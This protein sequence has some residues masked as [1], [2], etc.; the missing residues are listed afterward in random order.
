MSAPISVPILASIGY[1][2]YYELFVAGPESRDLEPCPRTFLLQVL[3]CHHCRRCRRLLQLPRSHRR[4]SLALT[5]TI[6]P[7][8]VPI[9]VESDSSRDL[10][11]ANSLAR[12]YAL[13]YQK[14]S[15]PAQDASA[16]RLAS[17]QLVLNP[18]HGRSYPKDRRPLD[19]P[20]ACVLKI[21]VVEEPGTAA[22]QEHEVDYECALFFS[23]SYHGPH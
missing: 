15:R 8:G 12:R 5:L 6:L 22:V 2:A 20:P 4:S 21:F 18:W 13:R 7:G 3:I 9:S 10:P 1:Y 17:R 23:I 16:S 19:P 11:L 14:F